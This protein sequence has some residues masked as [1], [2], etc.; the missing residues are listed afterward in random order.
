MAWRR[1]IAGAYAAH[2]PSGR[3]RGEVVAMNAFWVARVQFAAVAQIVAFGLRRQ[4]NALSFNGG[5][6]D[7]LSAA[8]L[9][10]FVSDRSNREQN[11]KWRDKG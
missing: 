10:S 7:T 11:S 9:F 6:T 1:A 5:S 3:R 4:K 8:A 2:L